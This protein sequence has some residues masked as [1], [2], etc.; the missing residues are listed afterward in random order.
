MMISIGKATES[1]NGRTSRPWLRHDTPT[2]RRRSN[3]STDSSEVPGSTGRSARRATSPRGSAVDLAIL[4]GKE[5][6]I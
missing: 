6:G 3:F 5:R 2:L 4:D 1:R